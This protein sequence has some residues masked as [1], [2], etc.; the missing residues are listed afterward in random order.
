MPSLPPPGELVRTAAYTDADR[1]R[2]GSSFMVTVNQHVSVSGDLGVYSPSWNPGGTPTTADLAYAVYVFDI[3]GYDLDPELYLR[4]CTAPAA[5]DVWIGVSQWPDDAWEFDASDGSGRYPLVS[6]DD[7]ISDSGMLLAVVVVAG[8]DECLLDCLRLGPVVGVWEIKTVDSYSEA[9]WV[10][11]AVDSTCKP[12][13]VWH[14]STEPDLAEGVYKYFDGYEWQTGRAFGFTGFD[15]GETLHWPRGARI[16][17]D[18][19][20]R[21]HI[22]IHDD[23][24][25]SIQRYEYF[26]GTEWQAVDMGGLCTGDI[27][28]VLDSNDTP[29]IA[30]AAG[31]GEL[32]HA[33]CTGSEWLSEQIGT[34]LNAGVPD[35][36]L[37]STDAP[38]I[39][40]YDYGGDQVSLARLID[41]EWKFYSAPQTVD[42]QSSP[43]V[44]V[45]G[46]GFAAFT[47]YHATGEELIYVSDTKGLGWNSVVVDSDGNVG[48]Y[49]SLVFDSLDHPHISYF[50]DGSNILK[51]AY[52]DGTAWSVQTI[53]GGDH[54]VH[55]RS[56]IAVDVYDRPHIAFTRSEEGASYRALSYARRID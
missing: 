54:L 19:A 23:D 48:K 7:Y 1:I 30:Y 32:Y 40:Y 50:D 28:L 39:T 44:A 33:W 6:M 15:D 14:T 29:H 37:S 3:E 9:H 24:P 4:W 16:A 21:P 25:V 11:L 2:I 56:S 45:R 52:L 10:S 42:S 34:D 18:S 49:G 20:D 12:H 13:V 31:D 26:D 5:T 38:Y 36:A 46:S 47:F 53:D 41:S 35:I 8:L 43:A 27:P 17:L 51:Y 55:P 22:M